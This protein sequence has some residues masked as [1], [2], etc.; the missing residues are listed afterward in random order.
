M[1]K[2]SF[3]SYFLVFFILSLIIIGAS[4]IGLFNPL[5]SFLKDIFSPI[6]SLTYG[7]FTKITGFGQNSEIKLLK[8]QNLI[9]TQKLINQN[10]LVG[11]NK[12][13]RDQFQT[14]NPRSTNLV[15][16]DVVGAPG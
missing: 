1:H 13:L 7:T 16:A 12:A 11:D 8:A 4:K 14:E 5:D 9:L 2:R 3:V 15:S 10:K 6:Q